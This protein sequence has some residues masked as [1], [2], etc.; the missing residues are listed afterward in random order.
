VSGVL[1]AFAAIPK[2]AQGGFVDGPFSSGDKLLARVNAGELIL[3]VAQQKNLANALT[4][5][6]VVIGGGFVLEGD[7]VRLMLTR[8]GKKLDRRT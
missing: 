6:P 4:R 2:F 1:A 3:N 8:N 7:M 5:E